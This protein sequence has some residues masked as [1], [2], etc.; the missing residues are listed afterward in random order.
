LLA[1]VEEL[2]DDDEDRTLSSDSLTATVLPVLY[3]VQKK[4]PPPGLPD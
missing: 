3:T 4:L 1:E 2:D